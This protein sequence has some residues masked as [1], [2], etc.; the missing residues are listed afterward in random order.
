MDAIWSVLEADT[1]LSTQVGACFKKEQVSPEDLPGDA[2]FMLAGWPTDDDEQ[3]W[4]AKATHDQFT[5]EFVSVQYGN[6]KEDYDAVT[7]TT[8]MAKTALLKDFT[9]GAVLALAGVFKITPGG[10]GF[11]YY[12]GLRGAPNITISRWRLKV[13]VR[14]TNL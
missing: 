9:G 14:N 4:A 11:E 5:M 1:D 6:N 7:K 10:V 3:W 12:T 13:D 2:G 8:G